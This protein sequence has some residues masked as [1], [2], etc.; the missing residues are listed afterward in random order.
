MWSEEEEEGGGGG[1]A[2][3]APKH[4]DSLPPGPHWQ[5]EESTARLSDRLLH[6]P[7]TERTPVRYLTVT[8]SSLQL[9]QRNFLHSTAEL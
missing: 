7:H 3:L 9:D 2:V 5:M 6:L 4:L 8:A 1:S